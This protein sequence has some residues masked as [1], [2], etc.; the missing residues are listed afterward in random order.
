MTR[1]NP[2]KIAAP[3]LSIH[4]RAERLGW[5]RGPKPRSAHDPPPRV[6]RLG[7]RPGGSCTDL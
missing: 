1:P 5:D 3:F 7:A 6:V 4:P 2:G